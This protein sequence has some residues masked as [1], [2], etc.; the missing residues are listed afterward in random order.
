MGTIGAIGIDPSLTCTGLCCIPPDW[1]NIQSALRFSFI[2]TKREPAF[3]DPVLLAKNEV[4][5]YLAIADG[6]IRFVK[7]CGIKDVAIEGYAFGRLKA[8]QAAHFSK[9]VEMVGI[10]K[11][12]LML[13]C[14][15]PVVTIVA[16]SARAHLTGGLKRD[17]DVKLQVAR[18]MN[19]F[20]F[21]FDSFDE[22]DAFVI[23]NSMYD[24]INH[25]SSNFLKQYSLL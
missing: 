6:V 12:Q 16:S 14:S 8:D 25:R 20:G 7:E 15:I 22:M 24:N 11:S 9:T 3:G 18:H 5:R 4:N 10:V 23:A 19:G 2:K 13:C 21:D 1:N 17:G